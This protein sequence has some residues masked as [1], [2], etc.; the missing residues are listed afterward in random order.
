MQQQQKA[1]KAALAAA[2]F[3]PG[4]KG[5]VPSRRE[6]DFPSPSGLGLFGFGKADVQNPL[7]E[8]RG[9]KGG[10]GQDGVDGFLQ[11]LDGNT[12]VG[13]QIHVFGE[14]GG[15]MKQPEAHPPFY[16]PRAMGQA[17]RE[18]LQEA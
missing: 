6:Q 4:G 9:P 13:V 2:D 1:A 12:G 3:D 8:K 16:R 14:P 7:G 11:G 10:G 17:S 15:P 5:N 18:V